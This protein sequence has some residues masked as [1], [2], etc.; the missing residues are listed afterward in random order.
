MIEKSGV[1]TLRDLTD[2]LRADR[3]A[4]H[5]AGSVMHICLREVTRIVDS[6]QSCRS[7]ARHR[8]DPHD[9]EPRSHVSISVFLFFFLLNR[10]GICTLANLHS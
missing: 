5:H 2:F 1:R 4:Q 9:R 10:L 7:Y 8:P 3:V 6:G